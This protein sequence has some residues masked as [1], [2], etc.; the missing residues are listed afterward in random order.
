[1][2]SGSRPRIVTAQHPVSKP[3]ICA[4]IFL[5]ASNFV[6]DARSYCKRIS[7]TRRNP[8]ESV[9]SASA[10]IDGCDRFGLPTAFLHSLSTVCRLGWRSLAR[11]ET[12]FGRLQQF[13]IATLNCRGRPF[14]VTADQQAMK[15]GRC[16]LWRRW[17]PSSCLRT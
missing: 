9:R 12:L 15:L 10:T 13:T 6:D 11:I 14:A 1:M 17:K 7:K 4:Q 8:L 3:Y 16:G 5:F 2:K